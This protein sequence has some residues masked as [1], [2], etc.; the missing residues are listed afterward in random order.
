[1]SE[2]FEQII[3]PNDSIEQLCWNSSTWS[4]HVSI[5][6]VEFS[7][8]HGT[9][10]YLRF[11]SENL[12]ANS[13]TAKR[14]SHTRKSAQMS[15]HSVMAFT[16]MVAPKGAVDFELS[17]FLCSFAADPAG[18]L[19][20]L[21]HDGDP[22]R[23]DGAQVGVFKQTHHI[24]LAGLLK[25]HHSGTLEAQVGL[26]VLSDLTDQALEGQLAD[27]KLGGFLVTTD[28]T[29]SDSSR[30]ISVRFLHST[31]GRRALSRCLG[32]KLFSWSLPSSWLSS[33]LLS[34]RHFKTKSRTDWSSAADT[35][36]N[37]FLAPRVIIG[38]QGS[39]LIG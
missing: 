19:D 36:S 6:R 34:T 13:I 17:N 3:P 7:Q 21:G 33:G 10:Y 31:G 22:L 23:V 11:V 37:L 25:G 2:E 8:M 12:C 1:M 16:H 14:G 28:L 9:W 29:E 35:S 4:R 27:Q 18:K 5:L 30:S 15:S 24:G 26:E 38:W 20:I 39:H 32:G